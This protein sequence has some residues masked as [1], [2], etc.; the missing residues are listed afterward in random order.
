VQQ[1]FQV[2]SGAVV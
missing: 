2:A 1:Q